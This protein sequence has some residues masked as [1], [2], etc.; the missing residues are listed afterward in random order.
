MP[1]LLMPVYAKDARPGTTVSE[2][3]VL[4]YRIDEYE[5]WVRIVLYD[6]R[7]TTLQSQMLVQHKSIQWQG[8]LEGPRNSWDTA[9]AEP[10]PDQCPGC[11]LHHDSPG[12][13]IFREG[14]MRTFSTGGDSYVTYYTG[15]W[16]CVN[17]SYQTEP[18]PVHNHPS[19]T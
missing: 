1:T 12:N 10:I 18:Q 19:N 6:L 4:H 7:T 17:C 15:V 8:H 3:N 5:Q 16:E 2:S 14:G 11:R 9:N 13:W